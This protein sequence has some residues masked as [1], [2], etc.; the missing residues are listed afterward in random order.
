MMG[1]QQGDVAGQSQKASWVGVGAGG[2]VLGRSRGEV[3]R[4]VLEGNSVATGR[5]RAGDF[6]W[7]LELS[8]SMKPRPVSF[9][10]W[11]K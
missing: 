10:P 11:G 9:T 6:L 1:L 7:D 3:W 2:L 5:P 8:S 4:A